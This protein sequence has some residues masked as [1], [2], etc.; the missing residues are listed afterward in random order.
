MSVA[1]KLPTNAD[2]AR[3]RFPATYEQAKT[4][5]ASCDNVDECLDWANKAEALA[6]YAKMADDDTLRTLAD[7][8]QARAIR[9]M[10]ELLKEFDGKGNNQHGVG[11]HTTQREIAE[12]AG[13]SKHQQV[14]AV[15]VANVP[16]AHFEAAIESD[17]P[18]TVTQLAA[19]GRRSGPVKT[20]EF[21][22]E[23]WNQLRAGLDAILALPLPT[24]VIKVVQKNGVRKKQLQQRTAAFSWIAQF[25]DAW[26]ELK[27][28][29]DG[30]DREGG[31]G[32]VA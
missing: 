5:L 25:S 10:G 2:I 8:I 21:E 3:A 29:T 1:N 15:R 11:A 12:S 6:A 28:S 23:I 22:S 9:R 17:Q 7:R 30:R 26:T 4:A 18:P 19:L 24:D 32:D 13:I 20:R 16:V 31:D 27:A 14:Q